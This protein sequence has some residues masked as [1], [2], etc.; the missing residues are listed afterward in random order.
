MEKN[1][2]LVTTKLR[3]DDARIAYQTALPLSQSGWDVSVISPFCT[4]KKDNVRFWGIPQRHGAGVLFRSQNALLST[5]EKCRAGVLILEDTSLLP[6]IPLFQNLGRRVIFDLRETSDPLEHGTGIPGLSK[7]ALRG[8]LLRRYLPRADGVLAA[9]EPLSRMLGEQGIPSALVREYLTEKETDLI[10]H[11]IFSETQQENTVCLCADL[12]KSREVHFWIQACRRAGARL[13]L[14]GKFD[15][16]SLRSEI[17][18]LPQAAEIQYLGEPDA[19]SAAHVFA[20]TQAALFLADKRQLE[21]GEGFGALYRPLAAGL[22]VAAPDSASLRRLDADERFCFFEGEREDAAAGAIR[23]LLD[24]APRRAQV[25]FARR[26]M[27]RRFS[28]SGSGEKDR[29]LELCEKVR[30]S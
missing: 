15:P 29:L 11:A 23:S 21:N 13:L 6:M 10:E 14:M 25:R 24:D 18:Q 9:S 3:A 30:R 1:I 27:Q 7:E 26:A 20:R 19:E 5:V 12:C 28:F 2:A 4:A 22:P 8:R 17:E 16:P